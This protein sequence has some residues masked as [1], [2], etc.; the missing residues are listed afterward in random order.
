MTATRR[1]ILGAAAALPLAA[2]TRQRAIV[3]G[4]GVFGAWTAEHLQRAGWDVLLVDQMGPANARASSGGESRMTRGTYGRDEIYTRMALDSLEEWKRLSE[5]SALPLFH[6]AG[7][8]FC[9][10]EMID[11]ARQSIEVHTR[12]GLPLEQIDNAALQARWPQM[13]FDGIAFGLFEAEFGALMARRAVEETVARF[14]ARGGQFTLAHAKAG[15]QGASVLLDEQRHDASA[16]VWACGP[17]LPKVF[18]DV[19]GQRVFVTRQEVAFIAPPDGD[20]S[21]EASHLP[22]WADFNGGDLYYGFPNLEGRGFKI[23]RDTHGVDFDPDTGDRR[24]TEEGAALLRTFAERRFPA[25]A[26]RPFTEFRVCQYENS[27]NGDFL[28]DR[29]PTFD[30]VYLL[31][32]GSGHGFKH[33]PEVG[34]MMAELVVNG[35]AP[36]QRF[37][38][39]TKATAHNRTVL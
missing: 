11:Y 7:V 8:L 6:N 29:H 30:G 26:G 36:D 19:L 1:T 27:S 31:G 20:D 21:F 3:V 10:Q 33:G 38:L 34:R 24:I 39:A 18:P 32:G 23:A 17:W 25:L 12:L 14:V 2:C 15:T 5:R 35:T 9:F 22:G 16:V 4:A 28:I 13:N 37:S